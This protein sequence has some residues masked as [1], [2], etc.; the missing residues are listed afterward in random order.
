VQDAEIPGVDLRDLI[1]KSIRNRRYLARVTAQDAGILSGMDDLRQEGERI[2]VRFT[3]LLSDG[4]PVQINTIVAELVGTP[5]QIALCEDHL[6]GQVA[7]YSGVATAA[8]R[9]KDLAGT[10]EV[11]CGAWKKMPWESKKALRRAIETGGMRTR[12]AA[13]NF[14]Y[15]DKNYVRMFGTIGATLEAVKRLDNRV[16]AIQVRGDTDDIETEAV[17]A[18]LG[19][20][21]ILMIDTGAIVDVRRVSKRLRDEGLR[22]TVKLAFAGSV[23]IEQLPHLKNEDI[24]I[25]DIGRAVIDAPLLDM[26]LEVEGECRDL[27]TTQQGD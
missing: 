12:I 9:A 18:A 20:A 26:R 1:F 27:T 24:D 17:S 25:L 6:I 5:K 13:R 16:K 7:K 10:I 14:V 19:G 15:L 2:G 8:A 3:S 11:V 23:R 22:S 4:A 21:D